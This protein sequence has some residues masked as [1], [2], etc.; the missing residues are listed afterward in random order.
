MHSIPLFHLQ[1]E[2]LEAQS[3]KENEFKTLAQNLHHLLST[4]HISGIYNPFEEFLEV[5]LSSWIIEIPI[6]Y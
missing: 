2:K 5:F 4:R 1:R 3:K 6:F